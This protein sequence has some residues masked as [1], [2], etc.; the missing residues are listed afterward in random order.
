MEL[1]EGNA[2]AEQ[3]LEEFTVTSGN[4]GEQKPCGVAVQL[5]AGRVSLAFTIDSDVGH[6]YLKALMGR[7]RY[8]AARQIRIKRIG[9]IGQQQADGVGLTPAQLLGD[10]IRSV[11]QLPSRLKDPFPQ[12]RA[13]LSAAGQ[14][15]G[16]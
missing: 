5:G 3:T 13:H 2:S 7:R 6:K 9:Y 12:L 4:G 14:G 16:H 8:H 10:L 15:V 11:P 1:H